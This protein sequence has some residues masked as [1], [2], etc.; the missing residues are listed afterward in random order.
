M[1]VEKTIP[2]T[3]NAFIKGRQILDFVIIANNCFDSRIRFGEPDMLCKLDVGKA[4]D[5]VNGTFYCIC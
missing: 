3:Q 4:Y 5:H 1:V 2:K